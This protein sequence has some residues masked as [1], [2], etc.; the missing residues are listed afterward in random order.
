MRVLT[1]LTIVA[2]VMGPSSVLAFCINCAGP[3]FSA[4]PFASRIPFVADESRFVSFQSPDWQIIALSVFAFFV[5][6]CIF[7]RVVQN[8]GWRV[9]YSRKF[10]ALICFFLPGLAAVF[11]FRDLPEYLPGEK[12]SGTAFFSKYG[13]GGYAYAPGEVQRQI[14]ASTFVFTACLALLSSPIRTRIPV[15]ATVFASLDRPED[16]PFTLLWLTTSTWT[17]MAIVVLWLWFAP[18]HVPYVGIALIIAGVGDALAEPVGLRFGKRKYTVPSLAH[19][20][21]YTRSLEGSA[22]VWVVGVIAVLIAATITPSAFPPYMFLI[23]LIVFPLGGALAE[24]LAPHT[25]DQ[26]FIILACA[27]IAVMLFGVQ[28]I[29][30]DPYGGLY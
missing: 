14:I 28:D 17:M 15:L 8:N 18:L 1:F 24:G 20:R 2:L 6:G 21:S 16:R 10:A 25:W 13:E 12:F 5:S 27:L 3:L 7:G 29:R 19:G 26:P 4:N 11:L 9:G 23:A 30:P 22:A